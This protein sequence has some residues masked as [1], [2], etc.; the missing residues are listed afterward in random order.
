MRYV[1]AAAKNCIIGNSGGLALAYLP[2]GHGEIDFLIH[3]RLSH[4]HYCK[5]PT[6]LR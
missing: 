3:Q 1:S 4:R 2:A 5:Q 6:A